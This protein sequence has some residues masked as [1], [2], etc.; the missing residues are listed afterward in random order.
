MLSMK[1]EYYSPSKT[2][3]KKKKTHIAGNW[4][5][6]KKMNTRWREQM[7]DVVINWK[8]SMQPV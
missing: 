1:R 4:M 5:K 7:K 2:L 8:N 3:Q 6:M